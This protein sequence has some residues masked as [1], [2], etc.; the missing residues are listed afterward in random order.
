MSAESVTQ[1]RAIPLDIQAEAAAWIA[2]LHGT[3]R[4]D[5]DDRSFQRW[6][7]A[8]VLHAR[9]FERM[10]KLWEAAAGLESRVLENQ[11]RRAQRT[12]ETTRRFGLLHGL[13]LACALVAVVMGAFWFRNPSIATAIGERRNLTLEDGTRL[14]LN[15][16]THVRIQY[17]KTQRRLT[18][19]TG[20]VF[21][22]VA[23]QAERPFIVSTENAEIKVLG[24]AFSIRDDRHE[25][26]VTLVEGKV[27]VTDSHHGEDLSQMQTPAAPLVFTLLPGERL[28]LASARAP[29]LD[30]PSVEKVTAWRQGLVALERTSLRD[31][32]EEMNR[33]SSTKLV[34]AQPGRSDVEVSGVFHAGDS[35]EF[36]RALALTH[37]I[38]SKQSGDTI[39]LYGR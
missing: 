34:I 17:G 29:A 16:A 32:V 18:L 9:A 7:A 39:I 5:E 3:G 19:E 4:T 11:W 8:N 36:A 31:A 33:Y 30:H 12:R 38:R 2:R 10:T 20:E 28:T 21:L 22:E 13:G 23:R 35:E 15:T 27:T 37:G 26:E 6:M 25:T 1:G 24:T 14:T